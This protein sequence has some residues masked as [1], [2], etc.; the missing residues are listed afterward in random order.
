[1]IPNLSLG[2]GHDHSSSFCLQNRHWTVLIE[3]WQN[4][5]T[6]KRSGFLKRILP[7]GTFEAP[8]LAERAETIA[9]ETSRPEHVSV[10]STIRD[11]GCSVELVPDEP[12]EVRHLPP[13]TNSCSITSHSQQNASLYL[14][15]TNACSLLNKMSELR[16]LIR[17][18]VP[19]AISITGSWLH[20]EVQD[21]ERR[22]AISLC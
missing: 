21:A 17:E 16:E 13:P 19:G 5:Q 18:K 15:Y 1:M 11:H 2:S 22:S 7:A 9:A 8:G 3:H 14:I 4:P 10:V 20:P 6:L 12:D